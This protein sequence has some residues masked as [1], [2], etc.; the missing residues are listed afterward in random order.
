MRFMDMIRAARRRDSRPDRCAAIAFRPIGSRRPRSARASLTITTPDQPA[1]IHIPRRTSMPDSTPT[2]RA[3]AWLAALDAAL[4]RGDA[5]AAAAL[6]QDD[7]YWRDLV[8]FTWNIKTVEGK[9]AIADMLQAT[10][11]EAQ[12]T[13][14]KLSGGA[15]ENDGIVEAWFTFET[16]AARGLGHV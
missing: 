11:K 15:T 8:A 7:C 14:W 12:P 9:A 1:R 2:Q 3:A 6:F 4:S 16:K 10:V 13:G 5:T